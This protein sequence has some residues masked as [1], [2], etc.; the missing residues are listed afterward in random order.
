MENKKIIIRQDEYSNL[1]IKQNE[2]KEFLLDIETEVT[3]EETKKLLEKDGSK[4]KITIVISK[5]DIDPFIA[6]LEK[7]R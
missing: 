6:A 3:D 5:H 1:T 7:M 4:T 2:H